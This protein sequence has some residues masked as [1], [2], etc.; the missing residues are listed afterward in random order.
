VIKDTN[1]EDRARELRMDAERKSKLAGNGVDGKLSKNG[2]IHGIDYEHFTNWG[3]AWRFG[4]WDCS[5][6]SKKVKENRDKNG[7]YFVPLVKNG[8]NIPGYGKGHLI[9]LDGFVYYKP[10]DSLHTRY[11]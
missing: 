3:K 7:Y 10:T 11:I 1:G 9:C 8:G 6:G 4:M 2:G 5:I